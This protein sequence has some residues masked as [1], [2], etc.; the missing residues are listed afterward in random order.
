MKRTA[1]NSRRMPI[2][3]E[4][5][6][7]EQLRKLPAALRPIVQAAR[8]TV[9][10][11]APKAKEIAYQSRPPRSKSAMWKIVRYAVDDAP[12]VAIGAFSKHASLFFFRGSELDG[13][14][15][16]EG[17]GKRL[18]YI[19]LRTAEDA[20]TAAVKRLVRKAFALGG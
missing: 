1:V 2:R 11:A 13:S 6:L 4:I 17:G 19:T 18:R 12:V 14:G 10:A 15:S 3:A 5:S 20:Q 8:R 16:L 7:S 9:K